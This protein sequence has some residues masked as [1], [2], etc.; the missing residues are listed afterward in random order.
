MICLFKNWKSA[1]ILSV[2]QKI[3]K[4]HLYQSNSVYKEAPDVI[5]LFPW[6]LDGFPLIFI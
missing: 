1:I 4:N 6:L 5:W 3:I 2:E